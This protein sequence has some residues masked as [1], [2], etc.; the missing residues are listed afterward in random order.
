MVCG[1]VCTMD[2][3]LGEWVRRNLKMETAPDPNCNTMRFEDMLQ[4]VI[5]MRARLF[6]KRHSA[7]V[8][9]CLHV[10]LYKALV[11]W[12]LASKKETEGDDDVISD[13][14]EAPCEGTVS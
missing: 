4:G 5:P 7:G 1:G 10:H 12:V 9:A 14:C 8:G 2:P 3:F 6:E 13:I 11:G